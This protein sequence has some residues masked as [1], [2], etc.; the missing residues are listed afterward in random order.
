[1]EKT[2]WRA[3]T[4]KWLKEKYSDCEVKSIQAS[5]G[6][7]GSDLGI[8]RCDEDLLYY[9]PDLI[10]IEFA[11]NDTGKE[12]AKI[13]SSMEGIV[14]KIRIANPCADIVF[15][16]TITREM[17][18][19]L[20]K[21]EEIKSIMIHQKIADHY[22]I[23]CV[24]VGKVLW[25]NVCKGI[26]TWDKYLKDGVHPSDKGYAVYAKAIKSFMN[27]NLLPTDKLS[28]KTLEKPL[29]LSLLVE[30]SLFD[31]WEVPQ[32]DWIRLEQSLGGRYP[33]MLGCNV[34]GIE[35]NLIFKGTAIG[36]YWLIAADSGDIEWTI[37]DHSSGKLSSWDEYALSYDRAGYCILEEEL[38]Q[39]EH[40]L[41]IKILK[42]KQPGSIGTWIRIGAFLIGEKA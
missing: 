15:I 14:R 41:K 39:G 8:F 16:Y 12:E 6:G 2:S 24:N 40:C 7:T 34:P 23:P 29:N 25:Q 26:S 21:G 4:T 27:E 30:A 42:E 36:L 3:L 10:F 22:G 35:L 17:S 37:D 19:I 32:K 20:D 9:K 11:V 38:E 28:I 13:S 1:M 18:L 31:A 5:I 33:H